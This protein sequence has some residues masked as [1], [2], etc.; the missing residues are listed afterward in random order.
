MILFIFNSDRERWINIVR[1]RGRIA[2][3][4]R[5]GSENDKRRQK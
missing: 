3:D 5:S 1:C 2:P 4:D